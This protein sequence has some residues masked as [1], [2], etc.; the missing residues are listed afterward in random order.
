MHIWDYKTKDKNNL[1]ETWM[2]ERSINFGLEDNERISE[3]VLR[4]NWD[5]IKIDPAKR[6]FLEFLLWP[7]KY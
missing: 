1:P 6:K 5:K 4:R 3:K 7:K 2:L